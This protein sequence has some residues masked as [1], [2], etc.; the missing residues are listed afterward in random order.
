[1]R[2]LTIVLILTLFYSCSP[3]VKFFG[4]TY[5][6]TTEVDT[7]YSRE[8]VTVAHKIIGQLSGYKM[9][10]SKD[11]LKILMV[12]EAK[13]RG[14]NGILFLLL[15]SDIQY[16]PETRTPVKADLILYQE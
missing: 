1:M 11:E 15:N 3:T 12:E 2:Y 13:K 8:D 7:Y 10:G 14:A 5:P 6:A 9:H 16:D 4:D